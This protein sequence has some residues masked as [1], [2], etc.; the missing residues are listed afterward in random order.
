VI[1][2]REEIAALVAFERRGPGTDAERRAAMHLADRLGQ[3]GREAE[4][5]QIAVFPNWPLTYAFHATL[6][7]AGS[8]VSVS[9]PVLGAAL[10]LLATILT[11]L[12]AN[13]M[14]LTTRRVLGRRASQNV[15]S[16]EGGDKGGRLVLVA[17]YDAGRGGLAFHPRL[18]ERRAALG[19]LLRRPIGPFQPLFYAMVWVLICCLL[20]LPGIDFTILTVLQ[21]LGTVL[22]ILALPFLLDTAAAETVPGANDN[23]SGVATAL[24]LAERYGGELEHFD[25]H[26]L[27]TGSE[28]ALGL[29]MRAHVKD[30]RSDL[31]PERVVFLNVDEVGRGTVRFT[32]REG[33]ILPLKTHSQLVELCREIAEDQQERDDEDSEPVARGLTSRSASDGSVARAAGF[34]AITITC[35]G[36]LDYTPGHH[37]PGDVPD[38]IDDDALER[39]YAFCCELIERLD[40]T[41]GPDLEKPVEAT[42]LKEED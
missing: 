41:V 39:A 19:Q 40:A 15:V 29:G 3:L 2:A 23:A 1:D 38:R 25:V 10:A 16:P 8:V 21:F 7:I 37:S 18:Q 5:E 4:T 9:V 6:A 34:P 14:A 12:D 31:D 36:R 33:L 27:L 24:R 22:L 30:R 17:H 42:L 13:G 11:F 32:E 26:V 28:E 20:R 35:K